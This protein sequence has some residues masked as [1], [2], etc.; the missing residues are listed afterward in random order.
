MVLS[1]LGTFFLTIVAVQFFKGTESKVSGRTEETKQ[2][3]SITPKD[4]STIKEQSE[5]FLET[6]KQG[7]TLQEQDIVT[8]NSNYMNQA[9]NEDVYPN[10]QSKEQWLGILG[11]GQFFE[12]KLQQGNGMNLEIDKLEG[13]I[14]GYEI[15][16]TEKDNVNEVVTVYAKVQT[17]SKP[18]NIWFEWRKYPNSGWKIQ[19]V[20]FN[21]G[22]KAISEPDAPKRRWE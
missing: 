9:F 8:L 11:L 12:K 22:I 15:E 3:S 7:K 21:A 18:Q 14:T 1:I 17:N 10:Q 6:F 20:S 13:K 16:D 5:A 4:I 2:N 19:A